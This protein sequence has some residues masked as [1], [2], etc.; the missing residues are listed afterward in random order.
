M[1]WAIPL[2]HRMKDERRKPADIQTC[3]Y[4]LGSSKKGREGSGRKVIEHGGAKVTSEVG[5]TGRPVQ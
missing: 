2:R 1:A 5:L 3:Q 4:V